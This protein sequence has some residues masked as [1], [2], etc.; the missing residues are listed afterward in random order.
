MAQKSLSTLDPNQVSAP[1]SLEVQLADPNLTL[2][3]FSGIAV[4]GIEIDDDDDIYRDEVT[5]HLNF[6]VSALHESVTQVG[7]ASISNDESAFVF[8]TDT[9]KL[10][11][12]PTSLEL[13]LVVNTAIM[14]DDSSLSRFSYQIVAQATKVSSRISG[15]IIMPRNF[16]DPTQ[17]SL[18]ELASLFRIRANRIEI[19]PPDPGSSFTAEKLIPV[20]TGEP[21]KASCQREE[22]FVNYVIDGCPFNI[23]LR[24]TV[25][26]GDILGRRSALQ[27]AGPNPVL[28]TSLVPAVSGVNFAIIINPVA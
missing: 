8:A 12:D 3:I 2:L 26:L 14:G 22:C 9:G 23:P 4:P 1:S 11:V 19:L 16:F 17:H 15:A 20:A 5:V 21:E 6:Y 24:V 10:I 27:V 18:S 7:L 25:E 13:Q 28:L